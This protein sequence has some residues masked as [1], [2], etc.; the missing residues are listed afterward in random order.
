MDLNS[1]N[2][3]SSGV[4]KGYFNMDPFS[5]CGVDIS[6]ISNLEELYF[7]ISS[8]LVE[9][10]NELPPVPKNSTAHPAVIVGEISLLEELLFQD[11]ILKM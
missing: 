5:N 1:V 6:L 8:G 10:K 4:S 11:M 3:S 9:Q 2:L 7:L